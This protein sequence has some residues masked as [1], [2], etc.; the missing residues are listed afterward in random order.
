[1]LKGLIQLFSQFLKYRKRRRRFTPNNLIDP[2]QALMI[3][4]DVIAAV[5]MYMGFSFFG[6]VQDKIFKSFMDD[7]IILK[8]T[9]VT[10]VI[11]DNFQ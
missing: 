8:N 4:V 6:F 11:M 2:D 7:L 1:V 3:V 9:D 5:A 10:D